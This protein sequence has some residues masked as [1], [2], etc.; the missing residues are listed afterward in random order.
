[1]ML[2]LLLAITVLLSLV[3]LPVWLSE[4]SETELHDMGIQAGL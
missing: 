1:M 3:F 2:L 4:S